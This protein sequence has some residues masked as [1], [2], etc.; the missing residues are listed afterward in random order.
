MLDCLTEPDQ[1]PRANPD[2]VLRSDLGAVGGSSVHRNDWVKPST[3]ATDT[4]HKTAPRKLP[5]TE[6]RVTGEARGVRRALPDED[7]ENEGERAKLRRTRINGKVIIHLDGS[8][9]LAARWVDESRIVAVSSQEGKC[10]LV[11]GASGRVL[12]SWGDFFYPSDVAVI[13]GRDVLLVADTLNRRVVEITPMAN[14]TRVVLDGMYARGICVNQETGHIL[15]SDGLTG[16]VRIFASDYSEVT[17]MRIALPEASSSLRG[18]AVS[19]GKHLYVC[20]S[21]SLCVWRF[22]QAWL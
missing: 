4:A 11:E 13:H 22:P 2:R 5:K 6:Q 20:D 9:Q 16:S 17:S 19:E 15:V 1:R 10:Y 8:G 7:R 3:T 18:I 12:G 21:G 14:S